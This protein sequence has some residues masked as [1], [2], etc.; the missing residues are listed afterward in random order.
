[1]V[2]KSNIA[3]KIIEL[4]ENMDDRSRYMLFVGILFC[5]LSVYYLLFMQ[6]HVNG[7]IE[8]SSKIK[9]RSDE[10]RRAKVDI[11]NFTSYKK[12]LESLQKKLKQEL[13]GIKAKEDFH[14]VTEYISIVAEENNVR[15]ERITGDS[16]TAEVLLESGGKRYFSIPVLIQ[17]SA[18]Y[19]DF[20]R[21]LAKIEDGDI[22]LKV[23]SFSITAGND[24]SNRHNIILTLFAVVYEE[25]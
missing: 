11:N 15:I 10:I 18:G 21:F 24:K 13:A 12:E 22:L 2:E 7:L 19:H 4:L 9:S 6:P 23:D 25:V 14:L 17:A 5:L 8:L 16:N 1:M 20:G 3:D